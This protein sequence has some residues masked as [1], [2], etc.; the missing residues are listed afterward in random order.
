MAKSNTVI[1]KSAGRP[2]KDGEV[3]QVVPIRMPKGLVDEV[4]AW[5]RHQET[6]R[7]DA[8]RR[9]VELGLAAGRKAK[10]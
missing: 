2:P 4:E 7:S 10:K 6:N 8:F 1:R 3:F 9:L 5:A